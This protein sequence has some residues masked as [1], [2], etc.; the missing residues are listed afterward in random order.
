MAGHWQQKKHL[1]FDFTPVSLETNSS[2]YLFIYH[3]V[4]NEA[5]Q[6]TEY[7]SLCTL[8]PHIFIYCLKKHEF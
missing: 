8:D 2:L 6:K 5:L 1:N 4:S 7:R 3:C